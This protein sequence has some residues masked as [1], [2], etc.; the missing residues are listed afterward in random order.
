MRSIHTFAHFGLGAC[1]LVLVACGG[2][3]K[4]ELG[5]GI[6]GT[7]K[8]ILRVGTVTAVNDLTVGG[9]AFDT[10]ATSV[11]I[12]GLV[13]TAADIR[14][15]MVARV[16]GTDDGTVV[17]ADTVVIEEVVKG[18]LQ[19]KVDA[20]TLTVLGQTV[21]VDAATRY[22]PG[23]APTSPDGL[24]VGD[25]LEIYGFVKS[26]GVVTALRIERESSLSEFRVIGF[27]ASVDQPNSTFS[28]GTQVIDYLGADTSDLPGGHPVNGQLVEVRGLNA[29]GG[30]GELIAT[31]VKIEDLDDAPD[32][33]DTEIEGFIQAVNSPTQFV[34]AGVTVNTTASTVY[35]DGTAADV[36]VGAKVEVEGALASGVITAAKVEFK[37]G[38]R[39]EGDVATKVGSTLT[40]TGL[41]GLTI[42]VNAQTTYD[43]N[44]STLS[45]ILV[46]D[47]VRIEGGVSGATSVIATCIDE[48]SADSDV[49]LRGPVDSSP[50]ASDPT[51]SILGVLIDT[52]GWPDSAF[53]GTDE[54][55]IGRAAFFAQISAGVAVEV[56]GELVGSTVVWNEIELED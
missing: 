45:D 25:A 20:T 19:A 3:S 35:E 32:N 52:S 29:L 46:G 50:A 15:G 22:G 2:G 55:V 41:G 48:R 47:H 49:E 21:L 12:G 28:I 53:K 7:G 39:L 23:I 56:Q 17:A 5:G 9:V 18:I 36:A 30:M 6:G 31:E 37:S 8:P 13:V 10:A 33:D 24:T 34:V 43:G 14:V 54:S 40:L 44:A 38:V 27:A 11:Q 16:N 4:P 42:T 26:P 51:L 1:L